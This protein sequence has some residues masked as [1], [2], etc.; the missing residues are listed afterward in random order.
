MPS[1]NTRSMP[2]LSAVKSLVKTLGSKGQ[3]KQL[4]ASLQADTD[5]LRKHSLGMMVNQ[6]HVYPTI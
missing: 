6:L 1:L 5:T 2:S 4:K 3:S